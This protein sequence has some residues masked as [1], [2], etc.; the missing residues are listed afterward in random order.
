MIPELLIWMLK[1][2]QIEFIIQEVISDVGYHEIG[3]ESE[4]DDDAQNE[5][6]YGSEYADQT[7][8]SH[9]SS[10]Y[11]P[12]DFCTPG[13]ATER[14]HYTTRPRQSLTTFLI[15]V[16]MFLIQKA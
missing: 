2:Q 15:H 3:K 6:G 8:Q 13:I 7:A 4:E 5:G 14:A 12:V 9:H 10:G 1:T 16:T 11:L